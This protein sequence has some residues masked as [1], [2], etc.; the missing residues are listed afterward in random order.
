MALQFLALQLR[1]QRDLGCAQTKILD[2]QRRYMSIELFNLETEAAVLPVYRGQI[3]I[4][5]I[6]RRRRVGRGHV[7]P[8]TL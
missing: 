1:L 4:G 8:R 6:R 3:M 2:V 5:G 7:K